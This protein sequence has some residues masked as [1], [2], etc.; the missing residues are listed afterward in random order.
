ML[1]KLANLF[2]KTKSRTTGSPVSLRSNLRQQATSKPDKPMKPSSSYKLSRAQSKFASSRADFYEDLAESLEDRAV[3][4]TE[5]KK[6]MHRNQRRGR[7]LAYLFQLWLK[8]MDK[9]TFANALKGTVPAMD[10]LILLAAESSGT[11]PQGLNFLSSTV[12]SIGQ[13][14]S[15]LIGAVAIPLVIGSIL[16]GMLYGFGK[17]MVPILVEIIPVKHWP[18]IGQFMYSISMAVTDYGLLIFTLIGLSL[19]TFFW[20][21]PNWV[22]APRKVLD[23]YL[24]FS[25]YRD[26][27]SAVMLVSL[28]GLM[29]SGSSLVGSLKSMR[30]SS[31]PWL[32]WH[33][34]QVLS[35]LDRESATPAKAFNTGVLSEDLFDR[36]VDYGERSSFQVALSKIGN[37]SLTRVGKSVQLKAKVI[38][39]ILLLVSGLLLALMIASVML[40]AQQAR[41]ELATQSSSHH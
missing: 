1:Q 41:V 8:R 12:R 25:L 29:Q 32:A 28:S 5:L 14:K 9:L 3:L 4:V 36:V 40:T 39:Y 18:G 15:T 33:M 24:P 30:A 22:G 37:Q 2:K 7:V 17:W 11:L 34:S 31:P 10:S 27:N 20:A 21:L 16:L 38:N 19:F 35:N 23:N 26:Y 13:I 6:H